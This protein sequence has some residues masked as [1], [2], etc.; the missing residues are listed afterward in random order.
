[1][2]FVN[3]D[4]LQ[5]VNETLLPYPAEPIRFKT[6]PDPRLPVG[7]RFKF[8]ATSCA[9]PNFPY[10][11]LQG[12]RI[13]GYDLLANYL[14]PKPK[15]VPGPFVA[16]NDSGNDTQLNKTASSVPSVVPST[17]PT[18]NGTVPTEFMLFLGDFIYADV[19]MYFG[20]NKEAYRRLYR[21]NYQSPSYRKIYERLRKFLR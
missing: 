14:W 12:R 8:L 9:T 5:D 17:T 13:K 19:P 11:P 2:W 3:P 15:L 21:R 16:A 1:M 7:S 20:D 10:A 4:R 18:S 6:F